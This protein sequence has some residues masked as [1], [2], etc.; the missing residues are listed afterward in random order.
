M[1]PVHRQFH[2]MV[3]QNI[4][5]LG[6][7][8]RVSSARSAFTLIELLV[9]IAIIAVLAG[10]LLPALGKAKESAKRISCANSLRQLGIATMMYTGDH[11]GKLPPRQVP[12]AWPQAMFDSY[13]DVKI[14]R[15]PSDGPEEPASHVELKA[16]YPADAAPRS[17]IMNGWNDFFQ[18]REKLSVGQIAGKEMDEKNVPKA[19]ATI[20]FGEKENSSKHFYMDLLES[21]A[22]N[23]FEEVDHN[24]HNS[25]P[26]SSGGSN[27]TFM[28]G[29]VRFLRKGEAVSPEN[30]WAVAESWRKPVS[31]PPAP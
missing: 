6:G 25:G 3:M 20:L 23:D 13:R 22:G 19:S 4:R 27:H 24:K 30:M 14:L 17:Y 1:G 10:M 8:G 15:C 21:A 26:R 11:D 7:S 29:S 18:E 28:D 5:K 12:N 2:F 9:V 16:T 31:L